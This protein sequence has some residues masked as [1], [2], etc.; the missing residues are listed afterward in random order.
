MG[1]PGS[2]LKHVEL[3]SPNGDVHVK[4]SIKEKLEPY[5]SG[6]RLYYSVIYRGRE[7]LLDS[8][9]GLDFKDAPPLAKDLTICR[10]E[11]RTINDMWKPVYGKSSLIIDHCN[12]VHLWLEEE[13]SPRRKLELLFRAYDDGA[14][15]RYY[16]PAQP[17]FEEFKLSSERSEFH[18]AYDHVIWAANYG[19]FISPQEKEFEKIRLSQI[20]SS[21]IIGLPLLINVDSSRWLAITEANLKNW[22]GMYLTGLGTKPNVLVTTLSPRLDEP[23]VLVHA[24]TPN[25]SPWRVIMLGETPGSLIESNI[26][27]NLNDPCVLKD[28]SWIK[29]GKA[30]WNWWFGDY[31]PDAKFKVGMNT[32]TMKY[33]VDFAAGMGFEY[34]IVDVGWYG[35]PN[36]P[37]VDITT[38][39]PELNMEELLAFANEWNVKIIVWLYWRDLERQMDEALQTYEKWGIAGVKVDFMDR[40]DQE[41]VDFYYRVARKAADHRLLV[42]FHGAYK[43]TG[44]QRTY[45]NIITREGVLG[46]EYNKWSSRVTPEHT[47]TIPFTRMLAGPMDFTP[48]GFRHATKITF[49][50]QGSGPFVM[51]TRCHQLAMFVVY[52][53]PIQAVCDSPYNYRKQIGTEFLKVVPTT[54]DE[55]KVISGEVGEYI[56]VARKSRENWFIGG[57]TNWMERE[58]KIPLNFLDEREYSMEIFLDSEDANDFPDRAKKEIKTVTSKD[59]LTVKMASGGGFAAYLQPT[60]L[61]I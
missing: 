54:W 30:A 52:E 28:V 1:Q 47:V 51:G 24:K 56:V 15:F 21:S 14:A 37:S 43:P 27:L 32:E 34:L 25:C 35:K 55:T 4:I 41:M 8:P 59:I 18:F 6:K 58:L 9:L 16:L 42:I 48:G 33:L 57:M 46:N 40:D 45:P 11:E 19:A 29:P 17:D 31:I 38:P 44:E 13:N 3:S 61:N 7:V 5:P 53:S 12:E 49:R 50:P 20:T 26:I 2:C 22:A 36:D 39:I 10:K 23:G 60:S